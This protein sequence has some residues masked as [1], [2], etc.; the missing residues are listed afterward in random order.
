MT[1]LEK[2][3][4]ELTGDVEELSLLSDKNISGST[5]TPNPMTEQI[6][7]NFLIYD[8][9]ENFS[10]PSLYF[11]RIMFWENDHLVNFHVKVWK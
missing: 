2:Q 9:K 4:W 7:F 8:T 10:I 6:S 1:K 3:Q 11:K 5:L